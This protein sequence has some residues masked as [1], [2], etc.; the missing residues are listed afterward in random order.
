MF[1]TQA[2]RHKIFK[3]QESKTGDRDNAKGSGEREEEKN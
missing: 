1:L 2:S 3:S